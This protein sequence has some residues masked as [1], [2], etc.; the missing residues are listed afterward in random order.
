MKKTALIR[1]LCLAVGICMLLGALTAL[2]YWQWNVRHSQTQAA[3]YVQTLEEWIPT[4]QKALLE[5]RLDNTMATLSIDGVD[6]VGMIEMPRYHSVLP[7]CGSW[8]SAGKYPCRFSGSV[9]D[10]SLQ[11]GATTQQG[12]YD[13]YREL[14]VGD[15]VYFTDVEGNRYAFQVAAMRYEAHVDQ[16]ALQ[17][18]EADLTL[19]VK[20]IYSFEYLVI[21]CENDP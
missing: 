7:V 13:F 6:F 8:G 15:S 4:P 5:P 11:I 9:Y 2:L 1:K 16:A 14:S 10:G 3:H 20:N 12:Q 17:R 19:F 18:Q 21:F